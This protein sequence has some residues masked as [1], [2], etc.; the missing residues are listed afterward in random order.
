MFL[1]FSR[2][3]TAFH[4]ISRYV[5]LNHFL[6]PLKI[7]IYASRSVTL[8]QKA[9]CQGVALFAGNISQ[10]L[11]Q[12]FPIICLF[13]SCSHV[14]KV[15]DLIDEYRTEYIVPKPGLTQFWLI[16][17]A[18]RLRID[19]NQLSSGDQPPGYPTLL[20][21]NITSEVKCRIG[22]LYLRYDMFMSCGHIGGFMLTSLFTF[23]ELYSLSIVYNI[24]IS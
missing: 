4:V 9:H 7:F 6:T 5:M 14:H 12:D 10:K 8:T 15:E 11:D 3:D 23:E 16:R 22:R 20:P 24:T 21:R 19:P 17:P 13:V 18:L 2:N 1:Q